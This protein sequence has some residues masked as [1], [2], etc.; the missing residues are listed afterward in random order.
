LYSEKEL[1]IRCIAGERQ[2][3]EQLYGQYGPKMLGLCSRYVRER[4]EAQDLL[5]DGFIKVFQNLHKYRS[6]GSFEGWVRHIMVNTSISHYRKTQQDYNHVNIDDVYEEL[7][8]Y[9]ENEIIENINTDVLLKLVQELPPYC[10]I[11]FNLYVFEGLK[12]REIAEQLGIGEGTSK[13]NLQDARRVL[14]RKMI[15]INQEAKP[16]YNQK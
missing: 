11:V 12:H 4:S 6:E 16:N 14:Q 10:K 1:I 7:Q 9:Q 3:Y 2:A 15:A 13:S 8:P 5:Q